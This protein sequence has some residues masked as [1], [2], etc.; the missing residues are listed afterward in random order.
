MVFEVVE[1][2][3]DALKWAIPLINQYIQQLR[4]R[5][6]ELSVAVVSHGSEQFGLLKSEA[7]NNQ[8]VHKSVQSLVLNNVPVHVCAT[9]A[10]WR[11]KRAIDFPDYV[12]VTP[13][14]PSK[15]HDYQFMGYILI[16]ID[17]Y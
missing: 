6:P 7:R 14:G 15:I 3:D 10:S 13:S 4:H 12:D 9:H 1:G 17:S 8:K 11:D 2:S 5:F 16:T